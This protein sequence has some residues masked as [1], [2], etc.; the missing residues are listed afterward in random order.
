MILF[1]AFYQY[2][3]VDSILFGVFVLSILWYV[4]AQEELP[5]KKLDVPAVHYYLKSR[6]NYYGYFMVGLLAGIS[7]SYVILVQVLG[8]RSGLVI[9]ALWLAMLI[10][11]YKAAIWSNLNSEAMIIADYINSQ[12]EIKVK[13]D[14]KAF[15]QKLL[16]APLPYSSGALYS[17]VT[18]DKNFR[19]LD[20]ELVNELIQLFLEYKKGTVDKLVPGEIEEINKNK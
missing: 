19:T 6:V 2:G 3:F 8:V 9:L 13:L 5:D 1:I 15:I 16:S 11:S 12:I 17:L 20:K 14:L 4:F 18:S 7:L 10:L